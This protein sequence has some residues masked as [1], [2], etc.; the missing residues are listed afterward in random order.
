M[1]TLSAELRYQRYLTE[2]AP[3][4]LN[5]SLRDQMTVGGGVR[6][7]LPLGKITLRPGVAYFH[8]VDDPLAKANARILT[9]DVPVLF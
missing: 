4:K 7:D 6:L 3:V 9:L 5:P 8:P 2:I 1:L